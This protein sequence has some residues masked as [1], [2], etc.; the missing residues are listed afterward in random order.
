MVFKVEITGH[1]PVGALVAT[2]LES[3]TDLQ[4][5]ITKPYGVQTAENIFGDAA[6]YVRHKEED[7]LCAY[8]WGPV[9]SVEC[10]DAVAGM[11]PK[12]PKDGVTYLYF[13]ELTELLKDSK[14]AFDFDKQAMTLHEGKDLTAD[15]SVVFMIR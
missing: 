9:N 11:V 7:D 3:T 10:F 8:K 5:K 15:V 4:S 13:N 14:Y 6:Y 1:K 2:Y 12:K